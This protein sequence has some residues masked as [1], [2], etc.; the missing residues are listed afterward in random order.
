M[1]KLPAQ[2]NLSHKQSGIAL[3]IGLIFLL[4]TTIVGVIAM[5]NTGTSYQ[6]SANQAYS[7]LAFQ[8]SESGRTAIGNSLSDYIYEREWQNLPTELTV[9]DKDTDGTPDSPTEENGTGESLYNMNSLQQDMAYSWTHSSGDHAIE[10]D[11]YLVKT[12]KILEAGA[13]IQQLSGYEGLG[14]AAAGGGGAIYY[15]IRS[16]GSADRGAQAVTAVE[17]R[18]K[19]Q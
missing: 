11:I 2:K 18:V 6:L 10:S 8:A 17:Y 15:E 7:E 1:M 9:L 12:Q 13:G 3:V 14:K 4:A 16:R 19:I 5:Q